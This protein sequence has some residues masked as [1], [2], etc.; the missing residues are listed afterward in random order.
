[1]YIMTNMEK[2]FKDSNFRLSRLEFIRML[3]LK[4]IKDLIITSL[5]MIAATV[6]VILI[7]LVILKKSKS[8]LISYRITEVISLIIII[9]TFLRLILTIKSLWI[10]SKCNR[11]TNKWEAISKSEKIWVYLKIIEISRNYFSRKTYES[12]KK[13]N[14]VMTSELSQNSLPH[15]EYYSCCKLNKRSLLSRIILRIYFWFW[16]FF[17]EYFLILLTIIG[18]IIFFFPNLV[19]YFNSLLNIGRIEDTP[20]VEKNYKEIISKFLPE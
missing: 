13:Q 10:I 4:I 16:W 9:Y 8:S 17:D 20:E 2:I 1:M 6:F 12:W 18:A 15:A 11:Q 14:Q 19:S 5:V 3:F 7:E